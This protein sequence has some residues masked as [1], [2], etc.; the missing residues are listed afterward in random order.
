[1]YTHIHIYIY[2]YIYTYTHRVSR[3]CTIIILIVISMITCIIVLPAA[4][5]AGGPPTCY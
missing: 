3:M 5:L 4:R 1:M 2:I